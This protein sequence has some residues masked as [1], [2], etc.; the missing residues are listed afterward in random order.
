MKAYILNSNGQLILDR[1]GKFTP[2]AI[3][4]SES[5]TCRNPTWQAWCLPVLRRLL[6]PDITPLLRLLP[7]N[8]QSLAPPHK[9]MQEPGAP[10]YI[11]KLRD[12]TDLRPN[13]ESL[14]FSSTLTTQHPPRQTPVYKQSP[15]VLHYTPP[16]LCPFYLPLLRITTTPHCSATC[17]PHY[18]HYPTYYPTPLLHPHYLTP[19]PTPTPTPTLTPLPITPLPHPT[20]TLTPL[21]HLHP[22]YP[23]PHPHPITPPLP[24]PSPHYPTPLLHPLTPLTLHPHYL[25]PTPTPTR[26]IPRHLHRSPRGH[27][28]THSRRLHDVSRRYSQVLGR[29]PP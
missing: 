7:Q 21:P 22:H 12:P 17:P 25:T 14:T 23:H 29:R 3:A 11:P 20:P 5:P 6:P 13:Q 19:T 24:L 10:R 15:L 8:L 27:F 28:R 26:C 1:R 18:T 9:P 16:P 4:P 2:I